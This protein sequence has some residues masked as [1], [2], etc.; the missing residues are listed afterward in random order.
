MP[1]MKLLLN[2][3]EDEPHQLPRALCAPTSSHGAGAL[4]LNKETVFE[5]FGL[6]LD[7]VRRLEFMCGLLHMCQPLELR[8]LGSY[9]ED[10]ARKDYHVLRDF[11][12]RANSP[13]ELGNLTDVNDPVVRSKILV[14]LSLL[15]SDSRDCAGILF[16]T[17][18]SVDPALLYQT[19]SC[20][21][22][23][24]VSCPA[25]REAPVDGSSEQSQAALAALEQLA[26]LFTM[27]SLHSAFHFHQRQMLRAQLDKTQL[28]VEEALRRRS[29]Q[30]LEVQTR[31]EECTPVS[32]VAPQNDAVHIERIVLRGISRT[33]G[34]RE[35]NFKVT[36]SDSS[37]S[38][39]TKTHSELENFLL[40]L[41]KHQ[42][43]ESFERVL[44]G[45]LQQEE[46][47]SSEEQ[48]RNRLLSAP[49]V[50]TR[51][52]NV[53]CFFSSDCGLSGDSRQP[54]S[55]PASDGSS[56]DEEA[57][58]QGCK[59][60]HR[61][62]SP[63]PIESHATER[64]TCESRSHAQPTLRGKGKTKGTPNG[65]LAA[66]FQWKEAA[67]GPDTLGESSS[68]RSSCASSP[69]HRATDSL[70]S[71]EE[72][73]QQHCAAWKQGP[74]Y[75]G[76]QLDNTAEALGADPLLGLRTQ[77][78]AIRAHNTDVSALP[79][80]PYGL[81][82]GAPLSKP[83]PGAVRRHLP[84]A[85]AGP[86]LLME[87][88]K[89]DNITTFG[90][91]PVSLPPPEISAMQPLVQR[92]KSLSHGG[93]GDVPTP[94]TVPP[95]PLPTPIR[96][97]SIMTTSMP[98]LPASL[99][100]PL[101]CLDSTPMGSVPLVET[102]HTKLPA[103]NLPYPLPPTPTPLMTSVESAVAAL[104]PVQGLLQGAVPTVVPTHTPGPGP[105]P[106]PSPALTPSMAH[107]DCTSSSPSSE[108]CV[109]GPVQRPQPTLSCGVCGCQCSSR[110]LSASPMFFHQVGAGARPLLGL[111]HLFPLTNYLP[112]AH[113]PQ[114][115]GTTL[116]P[117]YAHYG[118]LH[119]HTD[120]L[121]I[122][123][124]I[125]ASFCQRLYPQPYPG[126]VGL[127]PAAALGGGLN[128]KNGIVSCSNCGFSGHYTHDCN[129]PSI[130][131]T[132]Q[133]GFR[134]KYAASHISEAPD[135]AEGAV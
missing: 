56:Q 50:F 103:L 91:S 99:H 63:S 5:W 68:E 36:W 9:L 12:C 1:K 55:E 81:P 87:P 96:A 127:L 113:A 100:P 117:I 34:D 45:L 74:A 95:A 52:R 47:K 97:I 24:R 59:K 39:V 116:P 86:G 108:A 130:D 112:Q 115:N 102:P 40:K 106:S 25:G 37:S 43:N 77:M 57:F 124:Q 26:L 111:P 14:C 128:K 60:K 54:C 58:V 123:Q 42:C 120:L 125:S 72:Q 48:L 126:P 32:A 66:N 20:P 71:E 84:P 33:K 8:F 67:S 27:A 75:L 76:S 73:Q 10:L 17:L 104:P 61:N 101:P 46:N 121:G 90:L 107:S 105:S 64:G 49:P 132:Q 122:Q 51:D 79:F 89:G 119:S 30:A 94:P 4:P 69:Q 44:L 92:F 83:G 19:S 18:S 22:P 109:E 11:E 31:A 62:K 110:P 23:A 134:L 93:M 88:E 80:M 98:S 133:G 13:S 70:D 3:S 65:S 114:P 7:P 16:R 29:A 82:P 118:P 53:C 85:M 21:A 41:P 135:K 15:G 2:T 38:R 78:E 131:S 129:Q 35:Y 6:H 28:T